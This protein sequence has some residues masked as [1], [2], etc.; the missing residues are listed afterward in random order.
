[1]TED[2]AWVIAFLTSAGTVLIAIKG[3]M[4]SK[5]YREAKE[6][7]IQSKDAVIEGKQADIDS[8]KLQIPSYIADQIRGIKEL[9]ELDH[10]ASREIIDGLEQNLATATEDKDSCL[11]MLVTV[12]KR[13][14][15]L[16]LAVNKTHHDVAVLESNKNKIAAI[17]EAQVIRPPPAHL[18]IQAFPPIVST[19]PPPKSDKKE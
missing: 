5:D 7:I 17:F 8:L 2:L 16:K 18:I 6:A 4:N 9:A 3:I 14:G 12:K 19:S 10:Q 11:E 1:M 13:V 15:L